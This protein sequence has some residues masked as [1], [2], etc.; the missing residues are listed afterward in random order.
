[1]DESTSWPQHPVLII[2][3]VSGSG[4]ST[5]AALLAGR[6]GWDFQEGDD[7]H[8][9]ANVEKMAAGHP[10]SDDDR[11]PWL[12]QI[13][14]WIA[15]RTSN[16][17]PGIITCSALKRSYR[18]VLRGENVVFIYLDGPPELIARRLAVRVD[19][20]MPAALLTSQVAALE[21]PAA[22]ERVITVDIRQGADVQAARVLDAL[23]LD[24]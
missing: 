13:A 14:A 3:G 8:P 19:H 4:K 12:A 1:M 23:G 16:G 7:L 24:G 20:Y 2:M 11:M 15:T 18:D 17:R 6:L 10:L 21:A 22:D 5:L 9:Q